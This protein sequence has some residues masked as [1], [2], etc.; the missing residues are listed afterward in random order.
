MEAERLLGRVLE[1]MAARRFHR[2]IQLC[3][4]ALNAKP[5]TDLSA[6][7]RL[8]RA[9]AWI[10]VGDFSRAERDCRRSLE[11]GSNADALVLLA[12]C[13]IE[14][15]DGPGALEEM[16]KAR[17]LA[18]LTAERCA[19]HA[20]ALA[21]AGRHD[22][23]WQ[24][25]AQARQ[26]DPGPE[27]ERTELRVLAAAGRHEELVAKLAVAPKDVELWTQLGSSYTALGRSSEA[28]AALREAVALD[29]T[30]VE[31]NCGLGL[32]L[33]RLGQIEE[34]FRYHEH[35]Q[36]KAGVTARFGVKAWQRE[37][38]EEA[39][40]LLLPEQGLGDTI[41]FSRFVPAVRRLA[42]RVTFLV[43]RPLV[44]LLQSN[45]ELD[46]EATDHPG[47]GSADYQT[48]L[49]S[50]PHLLES[51]GDVASA[52]LPLLKPEP[53]RVKRWAAR[54]PAGR[55]IA[56]AWQGNPHYAGEPW[57]SIPLLELAPLIADSAADLSWISLQKNF[58]SE[59][60]RASSV[61]NLV[62]DLAD[63]IDRDGDAFVDSLAILS[64]VDAFVTTDTAL[65]H[66]AG[67][68]IFSDISSRTLHI[69][70]GRDVRDGDGWF[71]WLLG[72]WQDSSG[73][74]GPYL[75]TRDEVPQPNNLRL[76]LWVNDQL[77]QNA[78]TGQ[79][80]FDVA[81]T[82]AFASQ[83]MTLEAGDVIATGTPSGV[84]ATTGTYLK[85]GDIVRGE[86]EGLGVLVNPVQ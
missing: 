27:A 60:L 67:Y 51:G 70:Q 11:H 50:L 52:S 22:A 65:A 40:L 76:Q 86:I 24:A 38:L 56:F 37:P 61:A 9:R 7:L 68:S 78:N 15:G 1:A 48:L 71:D 23:A 66:V 62:L 82:I 6:A 45:A 46:P 14:S 26:L 36:K 64:L 83:F 53:E 21:A 44:R 12:R 16:E 43:P 5:S 58:G 54:L 69:A 85:S 80:I 18:P 73:P 10:E 34:G 4:V 30:K 31:V 32:A 20:R 3:D 77:K 63:E 47:F 49:L 79:V 59:Q 25:A 57:R 13:K 74:M 35:R 84:G 33:L 8:E 19:L 29:P 42:R 41:Q 72:K 28:V 17:G 39:H 55:K 81:E 2:A 75:V